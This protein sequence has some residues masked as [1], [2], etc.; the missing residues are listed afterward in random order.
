M[1]KNIL[2]L[3]MANTCRSPIAE[4]L[5][6]RYLPSY[7]VTSAGIMAQEGAAIS[8]YSTILLKEFGIDASLHVS[9]QV[10]KELCDEND[11]ILVMEQQHIAKLIKINSNIQSKIILIGKYQNDVEVLDPFKKGMNSYEY[12]FKQLNIA[13]N[14]WAKNLD[15]CL[16]N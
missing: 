16:E 7:N 9:K 8:E 6:Q 2:V 3:C 10:T 13:C 5:L 1:V 15:E 14:A 4:S 11:L 12:V